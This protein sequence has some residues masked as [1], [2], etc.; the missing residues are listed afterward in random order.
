VLIDFDIT[1]R[2]SRM[3]EMWQQLQYPLSMPQQRLFYFATLAAGLVYAYHHAEVNVFVA[4][5]GSGATAIAVLFALRYLINWRHRMVPG[6][7]E[8]HHS[9]H[10]SAAGIHHVAPLGTYPYPWTDFSGLR[11]T[12]DYLFLR[13]RTQGTLPIPVTA[14]ERFGPSY[15]EA[16][17]AE[18]APL[19]RLGQQ[20][21][22]DAS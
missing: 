7:G 17:L 5:M 13:F 10:F 18:L 8:G 3:L 21:E 20:A 14:L 11:I 12:V 9:L 22:S 15:D 4:V 2:D 19:I 16:F 1:P 6:L